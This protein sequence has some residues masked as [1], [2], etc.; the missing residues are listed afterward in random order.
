MLNRNFFKQYSLLVILF[1]LI[2]IFW[3]LWVRLSLSGD[4]CGDSWPLCNQKI[5]PE[6]TSALIE[7]IHRGTSGLCVILI[8]ILMILALKIYPKNHIVRKF[9]IAGF[10]LICLE[11]FIGAFL[12]LS[13]FVGLNT[14]E[15]RVWVLAFH[16]INSLL[17]MGALSLS[18]RLSLW[19]HFKIK[20]PHIYFALFFPLLAL[21]GNMASLAGQL[22]PSLSLSQALALD[23]LPSAHISL[24]LRP[25]HPLLAIAFVLVLIG[26]SFS[27]KNLIIL[28]ISSL[29]VALFGFATLIAL[30]PLWMKMGH[31]ILT[32][33]LW[34]F[35]VCSCVQPDIGTGRPNCN[36]NHALGNYTDPG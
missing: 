5:L 33:G 35:L 10:V 29:A 21:T 3:G 30:S 18:Y 36:T 19:D 23:L 11:A 7:W 31:L 6:N 34:I 4:A 1:T 24:K 13:G 28:T 27:K 8:L 25:F 20:K 9:S 22:F 14:E 16:L 32:Y 12:V 2:T 17:L 26:F 15:V